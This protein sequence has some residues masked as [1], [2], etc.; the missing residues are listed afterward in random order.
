M[1]K[2][3]KEFYAHEYALL[4]SSVCSHISKNNEWDSEDSVRCYVADIADRE[5]KNEFYLI[6]VSAY[7]ISIVVVTFL[8]VMGWW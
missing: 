5:F 3:K 7:L 8:K 6:L 4:N 1:S 2:L